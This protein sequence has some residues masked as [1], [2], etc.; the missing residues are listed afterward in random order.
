V[1]YFELKFKSP[2]KEI[3]RIMTSDS[4]GSAKEMLDI[5]VCVGGNPAGYF[6]HRH[7]GRNTWATQGEYFAK[8]VL[9]EGLADKPH[10]YNFGHICKRTLVNWS[11]N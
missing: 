6:T 10:I 5:G 8:N 4:S 9:L 11:R 2:K 7:N 1:A 3:F